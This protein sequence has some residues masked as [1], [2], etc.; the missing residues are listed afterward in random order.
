MNPIRRLN[1]GFVS[2]EPPGGFPGPELERPSYMTEDDE[3]EHGWIVERF[4]GH[5]RS[6][7]CR[8]VSEPERPTDRAAATAEMMRRQKAEREEWEQGG[9]TGVYNAP[10]YRIRN[11]Y[12]GVVVMGAIL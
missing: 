6:G 3:G 12:T 7:Q 9:S 2:Y 10:T 1:G 11:L 8:W 5:T 4:D